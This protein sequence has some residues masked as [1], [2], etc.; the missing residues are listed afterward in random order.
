MTDLQRNYRELQK[1]QSYTQTVHSSRFA[2]FCVF[3]GFSCACVEFACIPGKVEDVC[4]LPQF[5]DE[6]VS[7]IT[8][9]QALHWLDAP[10]CF[11]EANRLLQPGG[12]LS[13]LGYGICSVTS[14]EEAESAFKQYYY[15]VLGSH[16]A[17]GS[18]GHFWDIDRRLVD[19]GLEG[20]DFGSYFDDVSK[21]WFKESKNLTLQQFLGYVSTFSG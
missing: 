9:A 10:S 13:A 20:I 12:V 14:S 5:A 18:E 8:I 4:H 15:E 7:L 16:L 3:S 2:H 1:S 17:P 19:N 6:S 21:V 11:E